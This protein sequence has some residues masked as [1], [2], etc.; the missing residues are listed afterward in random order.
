MQ[1]HIFSFSLFLSLVPFCL[2]LSGTH[3]HTHTH[4]WVSTLNF[5]H[6]RQ[7]KYLSVNTACFMLKVF[8]PLKIFKC[9]RLV[10]SILINCRFRADNREVQ[11]ERRIEPCVSVLSV[12][13]KKQKKGMQNT[14]QHS[15]TYENS[16][17]YCSIQKDHSQ[18]FSV[19][20]I[21]WVVIRTQSTFLLNFPKKK[22]QKTILN[23]R[24]KTFALNKKSSLS[25][26]FTLKWLS[27]L[28]LL[29]LRIT[30]LNRTSIIYPT[31]SMQ[32]LS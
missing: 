26:T 21:L 17:H 30:S 28:T 5:F 15:L 27:S 9:N 3:T 8:H 12:R 4:T 24:K 6:C 22:K 20:F 31:V 11:Q 25:I 1:K 14:S 10:Q 19:V 23:I 32:H 29:S 7:D 13:F 18:S 2:S 16:T